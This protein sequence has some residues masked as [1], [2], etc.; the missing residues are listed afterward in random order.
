[1]GLEYLK[2]KKNEIIV[3]MDSDGEDDVS[4]LNTLIDQSIKKKIM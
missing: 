1:M 4:Y 2:N 3:I